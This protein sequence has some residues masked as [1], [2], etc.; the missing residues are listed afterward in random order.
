[1]ALDTLQHCP[2]Q[3][4]LQHG[5]KDEFRYL[6]LLDSARGKNQYDLLDRLPSDSRGKTVPMANLAQDS[7]GPQVRCTWVALESGQELDGISFIYTAYST[8]NLKMN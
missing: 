6:A 1:M 8:C 3:I 2:F 5:S 4:L 7:P